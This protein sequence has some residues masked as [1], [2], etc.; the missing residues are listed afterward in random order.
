MK[1][2]IEASVAWFTC[3]GRPGAG[4]DRPG[5]AVGSS[6]S[7]TRA[8][9]SG[10]AMKHAS[11]TQG[12]LAR[13]AIGSKP[14]KPQPQFLTICWDVAADDGAAVTLQ[15]TLLAH[16]QVIALKSTS[17]RGVRRQLGESC[18]LCEGRE[19]TTLEGQPRD[20]Q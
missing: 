16:R 14:M 17:A 20:G 7:Q 11:G 4:D 2:P 12:Q 6:H 10:N 9:R 3:P 15:A 1:L 5:R 19:P 18:D 13:S 8:E